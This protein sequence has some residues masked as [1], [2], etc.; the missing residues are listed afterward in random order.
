LLVTFLL[1]GLWHGAAWHFVA[2]G[3]LHGVYQIIGRCTAPFRT[4]LR[5]S[6]GLSDTS[7]VTKSLQISITFCL[8]CFAWIFFR[9]NTIADAFLITAKIA[10]FPVEI[11]D[12]I[13]RIPQTGVMGAVKVMIRGHQPVPGFRKMTYVYAFVYIAVLFI[14]DIWTHKSPG[15]MR[16]MRFPLAVRWV[17]YYSLVMLL[18]F[19]WDT[20]LSQFIYFQF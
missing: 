2:W 8:V 15:T 13:R 12:C 7:P 6:I 16:V 19:N 20:G 9:A 4:T 1:S 14:A 17:F 10:R 18:L 5:R 11:A 3:A